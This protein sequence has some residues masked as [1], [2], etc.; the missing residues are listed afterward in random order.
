M[1][2]IYS[3]KKTKRLKYTFD[4]IFQEFLGI[5]YQITTDKNEFLR[6]QNSKMNYSSN[7]FSQEIF[8][9]SNELLF[10]TD[11]INHEIHFVEY[12][13]INAFFPVYNDKSKMP[14]DVFAAIFYLLTRYEE[15]LPYKKDTHGRFIAKESIAYKNGFLNKP[16]VNIW[17]Y[18]IRDILLERYPDISLKKRTFEFVPTYDIDIAFSYRGKGLMRSLGGY[19]KSLSRGDF[20]NIIMRTKVLWGLETDPY[21]TFS[22][23]I[24][25]HKQYSLT[26]KYFVLFAK[27]G[28]Y[29]KNIPISNRRFQTLIKHLADYTEIG[30]HPSYASNSNN[31]LLKSEITNLSQTINR[32]ITFSRQHYLKL[33]L[34]TTYRNLINLDIHEDYTMGYASEPGFRAGTCDSYMFFDLDLNIPTN[35]RVH[36]FSLM[37]GTLKDYKNIAPDNAIHHIKQLVDAVKNVD[38]TFITLWHNQSLND[39]I[40]EGKWR[41]PYEEMI[42][43]ILSSDDNINKK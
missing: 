21:N 2:L 17:A 26:P 5:D 22:Y 15:Y 4:T 32:E 3:Y 33:S 29:D 30:I 31:E 43:Y 24:N 23:Q 37:E 16:V 1:L 40:E 42:Q 27:Y 34:P 9:C 7:P 36:P 8:F 28:P 6:Y 19:F 10:E 39:N 11:I 13:G 14:F 41:K 20:K 35:L 18:K 25:L 12:E 38:G